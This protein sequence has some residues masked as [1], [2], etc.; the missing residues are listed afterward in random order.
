MEGRATLGCP[1]VYCCV[2]CDAALRQWAR[3]LGVD[4]DTI[5]W[6]VEGR[7]LVVDSR[8]CGPEMARPV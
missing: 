2:R 5:M 1:G 6:M 4:V 7:G 8:L 3:G